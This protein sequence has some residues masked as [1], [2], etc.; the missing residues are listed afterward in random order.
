[1][2]HIFIV[3]CKSGTY[4]SILLY[5]AQVVYVYHVYFEKVV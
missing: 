4:V 3:F 1:M 5:F 2:H